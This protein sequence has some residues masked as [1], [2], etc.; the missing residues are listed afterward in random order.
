MNIRPE[1]MVDGIKE[2]HLNVVWQVI[3]VGL[4]E[5]INFKCQP[6][7]KHLLNIEDGETAGIILK[8][9]LI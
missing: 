4:M 6:G 5:N 3:R 1:N 2:A 9:Y 8:F 7:L